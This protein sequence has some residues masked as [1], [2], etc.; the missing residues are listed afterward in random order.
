MTQ[1]PTQKKSAIKRGS[2]NKSKLPGMDNRLKAFIMLVAAFIVFV[3]VLVL[4]FGG[5]GGRV[6]KEVKEEVT[7]EVTEETTEEETD[8]TDSE[9]GKMVYITFD[10]TPS[11]ITENILS[12]LDQYEVKA[13]FFV[14]ESENN[15]SV[16]STI[17]EKGHSLGILTSSDDE[18]A[19]YTDIETFEN[20]VNSCEQYIFKESGE[21][22]TIYRFPGSSENA[23]NLIADECKA[24][25][26]DSNMTYFDWN[27]SGFDDSEPALTADEIYQNVID[28]IEDLNTDRYIILLHD[29]DANQPTIEALSKII[30]KLKSDGYGF[31]KLTSSSKNVELNSN[32]S[33]STSTAT[34]ET[35]DETAGDYTGYDDQGYSEEV[36]DDQAYYDDSVNYEETYDDSANYDDTAVYEET[37]DDSNAEEQVY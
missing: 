28:Q 13:T 7:E 5:F 23:N 3:L 27:V 31:D 19:I 35:A 20:D 1:R 18:A 14:K 21:L 22:T 25:L 17:A 26:A 2:R 8:S 24:F 11:S 6:V 16:L 36:Y 12:V 9:N 4:V 29:T 30:E 15:S 34:D 10:Y 32:A 37:Y 33:V